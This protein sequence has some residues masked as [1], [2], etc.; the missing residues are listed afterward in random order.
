MYGGVWTG[1]WFPSWWLLFVQWRRKNVPVINL[2]SF[3]SRS[4][5][6][7]LLCDNGPGPYKHFSF[8][9]H[10]MLRF[11]S[12]RYWREIAGGASLPV[13]GLLLSTGSYSALWPA[14][15]STFLWVASPS[16]PEGTLL[17]YHSLSHKVWG[18]LHQIC[19][20]L[21]SVSAQRGWQLQY[22]ISI[23]FKIFFFS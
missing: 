8:A 17:L 10:I 16:N 12:K 13:S 23:C 18:G 22:V 11:V 4:N 5:P 1:W 7:Y 14:P 9:K 19:S 3:I 15:H 2:L 20:L 6:Y 21:G